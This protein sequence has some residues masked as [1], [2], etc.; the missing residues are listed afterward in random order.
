MA[1]LL[2]LISDSNLCMRHVYVNR[3]ILELM[4]DGYVMKCCKTL[5][6]R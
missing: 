5:Q 1:E 2:Q 4:D 3:D 6:R